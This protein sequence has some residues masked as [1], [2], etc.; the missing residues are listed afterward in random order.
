MPKE[1]YIQLSKQYE[2]HNAIMDDIA[3]HFDTFE[4]DKP[5][6][7]EL[8]K[9][10]RQAIVEKFNMFD[11]NRTKTANALGIGRTNLIKKLKKYGLF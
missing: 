10:E 2:E 5:L 3:H 9:I 4:F 6:P 11:G 7:V 1:K 8:E